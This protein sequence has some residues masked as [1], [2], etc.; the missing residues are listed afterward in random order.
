MWKP[1]SLLS[2][3]D[4]MLLDGFK[5]RKVNIR[6]EDGP[7]TAK[8]LGRTLYY[9]STTIT[10]YPLSIYIARMVADG[11]VSRKLSFVT[12]GATASFD[13][14]IKAVLS[15]PFLRA[16]REANYTDLLLQHGNE[17]EKILQEYV[18]S[19]D[20]HHGINI[21]GF[22]FN[23]KGLGQEMRAAKGERGYAEGV[24]ISHAGIQ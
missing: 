22:K 8:P 7:C 21:R 4:P 24:V 18:H 15:R 5:M 17:G 9:T 3:I 16:L 1:L 14:L 11:I 19:N 23:Q 6:I 20:E 13:G 2:Y 12:I 10:Y